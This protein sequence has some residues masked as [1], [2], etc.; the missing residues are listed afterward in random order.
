MDALDTRYCLKIEAARKGSKRQ[1][2]GCVRQIDG[3][4]VRCMSIG[5]GPG[6]FAIK[7]LVW[8]GESF[9]GREA[10]ERGIERALKG[11]AEMTPHAFVRKTRLA[12]ARKMLED[13]ASVSQ[14]CVGSG[15]VSVSHFS[16]AFQSQYRVNPSRHT[17]SDRSKGMER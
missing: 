16:R 6:F 7:H 8:I 9:R 1:L 11:L 17:A 12:F 10:F 14:A 4:S 2:A 3:F 13:G 15:F 5:V